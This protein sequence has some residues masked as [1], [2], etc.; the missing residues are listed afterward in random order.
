VDFSLKPGN[1]NGRRVGNTLVLG[2]RPE[3]ATGT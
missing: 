1:I 2:A 3:P